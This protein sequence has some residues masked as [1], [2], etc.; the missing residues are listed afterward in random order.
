MHV[1]VNKGGLH[2][3]VYCWLKSKYSEAENG[4]L[5]SNMKLYDTDKLFPK[6]PS[7]PL[8]AGASNPEEAHENVKQ[9]KISKAIKHQQTA[10]CRTM[11]GLL[12]PGDSE[13]WR[14]DFK[15]SFRLPAHRWRALK[16]DQPIPEPPPQA[17]AW[18]TRTKADPGLTQKETGDGRPSYSS[19]VVFL[20][21]K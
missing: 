12:H 14:L 11:K 4:F 19:V 20:T 15:L 16:Y 6:F 3:D 10:A 21:I 1:R 17:W 7:D 2:C 9:I 13:S 18:G 8:E 5:S